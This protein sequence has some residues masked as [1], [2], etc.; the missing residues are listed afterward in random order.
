MALRVPLDG[1][2]QIEASAGT[3]KT[4]T[5]AGLYARL[6]VEKQLQTR[7][8]LVMTFTKAAT[9]ELR[10][11]LRQRLAVCAQVASLPAFGIDAEPSE[12]LRDE[13]AWAWTLLTR[14]L[15]HGEETAASMARRLREAVT[16]MDEAAIFTIHGFCQRVLGEHASLIDGVSETRVLEPSDDDLLASFAADA[17]LRWGDHEDAAARDALRLLGATPEALAKTLQRLVEFHG[18]IEPLPIAED[19][20][21]RLAPDALE[22]AQATLRQRWI[23][24]GEDAIG[25]F[26]AALD[27]GHLNARSYKPDS[28]DALRDLARQLAGGGW[29][30]TKLLEKFAGEKI[31]G[32]VKK[33]MPPFE[34]HAAFA[35]IDEWLRVEQARTAQVQ[36]QVPRVLHAVLD[37]ARTWLATRKRD[38]SRLSYAD[39]IEWVHRGLD[40][41]ARGARLRQALQ[42][43]YPVALVDEFQDTDAR[44]FDIFRR[45]YAESGTL[46]CIGDPKQAIY[47][48]R[49]GDVHAYLRAKRMAAAHWSL[50]RNFRSAPG[51][52]T[53]HAA[54]FGAR[55][56]VFV[57][58]GIAFDPVAPGGR[59][60]DGLLRN[61][62]QPVP[63]LTLWR[64]PAE[65]SPS[66]ADALDAALA[67][68]CASVI[69]QALAADGMRLDGHPLQPGSIAVLVDANRQAMRMQDA[70][71]ARG[72]P[73]VCLRRE[74][75]FATQQAVELCRVLDALLAP[76]HAGLARAALSTHLLG[77]TL[78][79]LQT[80][81]DHDAAW[82]DE[83]DDLRTRWHERG[84]LAM[85]ERLGERHARRL[86]AERDGERCLSNLMQL[87]D[88]MQAEARRLSSTHAQRDWLARRMALA[89]ADNEDEQLRLESDAERV[90]IM[91][92][93]ASKGLEFDL[94]FM[95]FAALM[96]ARVPKKGGFARYH[97][98]DALVQRFIASA[99]GGRDA[100]DDAAMAA[101]QRE[102]LAEGVRKLYVGVTRARHACWLSIDAPEKKFAGRVLDWVLPDGTD[103]LLQNAQGHAVECALPEPVASARPAV[104]AAAN[105]R[106]RR[107]ER[108]LDRD[109]RSH[110][111]TRLA[112]GGHAD[113][114]GHA[115]LVP[116]DVEDARVPALATGLHGSR[117]GSAV[118]DILEHIDF[119]AWGDADAALPEAER[120]IVARAL[121]AEGFTT[122]AAQ[123]TV[124]GLLQR[125]LRTPI[126]D[127][128][129]LAALPPSERRAE[130]AFDFGISG[131]DPRELLAL[132][133]AHGYQLQ[134]E[135]FAHVG[136]RLAGLMNGLIDL[137][138]VHDG[139]WWIADYKTNHLGER[140]A[141]YAPEAMH[142][143]VRD[144]DYDLQYLIYT[145]ALHRW[146]TQV[147]GDAYDY[148]RDFGGVR[149]LFLRGMGVGPRDHGVYADRPAP[150][151]V[152][153]MDAL[154]RAPGGAA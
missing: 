51:L 70:L 81:H 126:V 5:I 90:Q 145:V 13:Q 75:V 57:E 153:A 140:V 107:F 31:A 99:S 138:F 115:P 1:V 118:H 128:L 109:W 152:Q 142:Q 6:V 131:V 45:L 85:L 10:Q 30:S 69:A 114:F 125:T 64:L 23:E 27:A 93:H 77:R 141:D 137:V 95:P 135:Q 80:M 50:D 4:Y 146:L 78:S 83:L 8:I 65:K 55:E 44:Q 42:A 101:A 43:Q 98:G 48:F 29:P 49:G 96:Q 79:D 148:A 113:G 14:T 132:L 3:G 91:T 130:M 26:R 92:I 129:C 12:P 7:Q 71:A 88:A 72:V 120:E 52:L 100:D 33:N 105:L 66:G 17:W 108:A 73:A 61:Q 25:V 89:D 112:E 151:L 63:P 122:P 150:E 144:S 123:R 16:R 106:A 68:C 127:D 11:R 116:P 117:F 86:L 24:S 18:R 20:V 39:Q 147:R 19:A 111:F 32:A 143:A 54:L 97:E 62:E 47:G 104:A 136:T 67:D 74:S 124:I 37:E 53:A 21:T 56:D 40:D 15:A 9:E 59:V 41:R 58:N 154:L 133:H 134:R 82:R 28:L 34:G 119:A 94:V 84:V 139:R 22:A 46:F 2:Q 103:A 110:S 121:A 87:G 102:E 36:A 35:A 76:R 149:Y 38:L 60:A